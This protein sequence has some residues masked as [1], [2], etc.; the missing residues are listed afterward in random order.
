MGM[1]RMR[2]QQMRRKMEDMDHRISG[3]SQRMKR[4]DDD[5]DRHSR[6]YDEDRLIVA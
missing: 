1:D 5:V 2:Q 4:D 3:Q 6:Y